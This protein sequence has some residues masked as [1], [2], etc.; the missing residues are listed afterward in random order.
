[1]KISIIV[2]IKLF[3][4]LL[5]PLFNDDE[6]K[7]VYDKCEE[8]LKSLLQ[9]CISKNDNSE[10]SQ[11]F[12]FQHQIH[13]LNEN[14]NKIL[15]INIQTNQIIKSVLEVKA[16]ETKPDYNATKDDRNNQ[17][18][19]INILNIDDLEWF[20]SIEADV[21]F[22]FSNIAKVN[23]LFSDRTRAFLCNMGIH[24]SNGWNVSEKQISWAKTVYEKIIE[25]EKNIQSPT[26]I[27]SNM[28]R[29][30]ILKR[31]IPDNGFSDDI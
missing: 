21:W 5:K 4:E 19:T 29:S 2:N 22:R 27:N 1:M 28:K 16:S 3:I 23:N 18:K 11:N 24:K 20:N 8:Y 25:F 6:S 13:M 7:N 12:D 9:N 31:K 30:L 15:N 26:K 17:S 14:I 10:I